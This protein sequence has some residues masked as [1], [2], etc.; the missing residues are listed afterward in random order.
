MKLLQFYVD[1]IIKT[2]I[3]EDINYIDSTTDLLIDPE[4]R[5][6]A[7]FVAKATGVIA[8]LDVALRVFELL[9]DTVKIA[10]HFRDGDAVNKGDIIAEFSGKTTDLLKGERTY[11]NLI[12]HMIGIATYKN[13]L[14]G[15]LIG[16]P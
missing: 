6:E 3:N 7:Y 4:D 8:G 11:I 5:S 2:A 15:I 12:Q 16:I 9:D 13:N 1:D 10:R 14:L